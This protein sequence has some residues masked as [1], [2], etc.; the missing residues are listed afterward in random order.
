MS[1]IGNTSSVQQY[2]PQVAYF[3]GDASTVAFTLPVSV[4]SAAQIIVA[5]AN[6]IQ[7][8]SSAFTVSGTTLTFTSAPPSG[9][10]NIWVQY[11]T[12][13]TNI[14]QPAAASV[15]PTQINSN[16]SLWNLSGSTINYTAGNVGIG[17][18]SPSSYG[19]DGSRLAVVNTTSGQPC[20][21]SIVNNSTDLYEG[22]GL[23]LGN[24]GLTTNYDATFLYHHKFDNTGNDYSAFN[25][26]QRRVDG[27]YVSNIWNVDYK[28]NVQTWYRPNTSADIMQ[29]DA[30]GNLKFNSGYG[31]VASAYGCRAWVNFNG[32]GTIAI[33]ASGNI[34]SLT[35]YGTGDYGFSFSNAMP[36]GAYAVVGG[37]IKGPGGP[38]ASNCALGVIGEG[39]GTTASGIGL[40]DANGSAVDRSHVFVAVFR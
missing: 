23:L 19:P 38:S 18:T 8:P 15:G 12:L 2:A 25:I 27:T 22:G 35:D 33:R 17:T 14:V 37:G 1:Y 13:Q 39:M 34:S 29:I 28:N 5:V 7:N 26:S 4:V 16:Y 30:S 36:D 32:T 6:V 24:S 3:S 9:T 31:S 10:N 20:N 21:M 40:I 11:T